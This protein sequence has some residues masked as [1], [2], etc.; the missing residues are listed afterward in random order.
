MLRLSLLFAVLLFASGC[1]AV[2][3]VPDWIG[4]VEYVIDGDTII[5]DSLHI[6]LVDI[7]APELG[8]PWGEDALWFMHALVYGEVVELFCDGVDVYDRWLCRVEVGGSDV[9]GRM[10]GAGHAAVWVDLVEGR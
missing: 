1:S 8:T 2:A 7:D 6:R 3:E 9:G 5:V 4:E 10:V